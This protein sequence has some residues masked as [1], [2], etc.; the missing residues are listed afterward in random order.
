MIEGVER[1]R[2]WVVD[3][4]VIRGEELNTGFTSYDTN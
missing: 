3:F 4:V 1:D 2:S